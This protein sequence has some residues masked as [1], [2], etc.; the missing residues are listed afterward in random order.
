MLH[1]NKKITSLYVNA[2]MLLILNI[3]FHKVR[4]N[5]GF[6]QAAFV[7]EHKKNTILYLSFVFFYNLTQ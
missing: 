6:A 1:L 4:F 7:T 3:L 2:H 5:D